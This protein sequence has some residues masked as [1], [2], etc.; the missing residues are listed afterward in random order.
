L[1]DPRQHFTQPPPRYTQATLIKKLDEEGIGRPST[2]AGILSNVMAKKYVTLDERRLLV[3]S[4]LGFLITDL[5]V[6]CFPDILN[7]EFTAGMEDILDK[8]EEGKED[9]HKVMKRFYTTFARDLKR[10]EAEMR[11]VKR[12]ETPTEIPCE[13]CGA[14]MVVKWGRN[15]EFLACPR[16]PEC[17]NT[18]NF[19]RSEGGE[20]EVAKEVVAE[21]VCE[22]CG[23]PMQA[24]WGRFGQF[25]GCS[26]Y[27]ECKNIRP[28]KKPVELGIACP[29]CGEGKIL[30]KRT[31]RGK[32]FYGCNQYPKCT[33]ATWE[34]PVTE[35]CP[36]CGAPFVLEKVTKKAGRTRR[37][38]SESCDYKAQVEQ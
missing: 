34:K 33:F 11:D 28:L 12:E 29:T 22:K 14:M 31:R 4:E 8:I 10:A 32:F 18:K 7:V 37:C 5:L 20:I 24:R 19:T 9:W 23:R 26:G 30:E 35:S 36:T 1:L 16:Y 38:H 13:R 21:E 25:F 27:P 6:D 2:Y 15:G 17:K 3:P